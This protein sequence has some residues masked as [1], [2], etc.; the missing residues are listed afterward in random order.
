MQITIFDIKLLENLTEQ[1]IL[2]YCVKKFRINKT[3]I[4]DLKLVK[5]NESSE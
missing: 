5:K 2:N 1:E 4:L 3:N